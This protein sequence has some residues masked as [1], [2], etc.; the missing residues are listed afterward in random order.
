[1]FYVKKH[2][3]YSLFSLKTVMDTLLLPIINENA[4]SLRSQNKINP[5]PSSNNS[6]PQKPYIFKDS[7][8]VIPSE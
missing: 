4:L 3:N 8:L 2:V 6:E 1:M 5:M 7:L